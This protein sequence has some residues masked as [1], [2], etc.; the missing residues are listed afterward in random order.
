MAQ[1]ARYSL[2]DIVTNGRCRDQSLQREFNYNLLSRPEHDITILRLFESNKQ[3]YL[4]TLGVLLD[5]VLKGLMLKCFDST[6]KKDYILVFSFK[7]PLTERAFL[8][9]KV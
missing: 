6:L 1:L 5:C 9:G 7:L 8:V 3:K 4:L 2:T